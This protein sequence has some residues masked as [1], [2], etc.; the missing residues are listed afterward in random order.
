MRE[1]NAQFEKKY[2]SD[3]KDAVKLIIDYWGGN[4]SFSSMP[5]VVQDYCTASTL[6]NILD[7][8]TAFTFNASSD[9]YQN[10]GYRV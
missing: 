6:T 2:F 7:W 9:V 3:K 10:S 8:R 5:K 4:G 1:I